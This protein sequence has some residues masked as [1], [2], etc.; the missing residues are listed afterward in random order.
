MG[1]HQGAL[2]VYIS[3]VAKVTWS[4]MIVVG[5]LFDDEA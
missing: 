3:I 5:V 4:G 1:H 2:K